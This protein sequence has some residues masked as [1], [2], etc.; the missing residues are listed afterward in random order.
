MA[1][2]SMKFIPKAATASEFVTSAAT[3][4][5]LPEGKVRICYLDKYDTKK[6]PP[7][8]KRAVNFS[9]GTKCK[10]F[11][12]GELPMAFSKDDEGAEA[13]FRVKSEGSKIVEFL[14]ENETE[15]DAKFIDFY[16]PNGEGTS[17]LP[18]EG[19]KW[20]KDDPY[21]GN[22]LQFSA[23]FQIVGGSFDGKF[24][25]GYYQ[26]SKTGVSRKEGH[27]PYEFITFPKDENGN[28]GLGFDVLPNGTTGAVWSDKVYSLRHCGMLEGKFIPFPEDGNPLPILEQRMQQANKIVRVEI[29]NGGVYDISS[30]KKLVM[31][32][33]KE[34]VEPIVPVNVDEM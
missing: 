2:S 3:V 11:E 7:E 10:I 20:N 28:V 19:M 12:F 25:F 23:K 32:H 31:F 24:V 26:F 33:A 6:T 9:D 21:E 4:S 16:R 15:L 1:D 30:P 29:K 17:P 8:L 5:I 13:I 18:T 22:V 14:P 27:R 34:T